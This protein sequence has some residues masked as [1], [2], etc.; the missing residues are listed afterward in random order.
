MK[1]KVKL[2]SAVALVATM[3]VS[4]IEAQDTVKIT[5]DLVSSYI[6]RGV[7][8]SRQ[9]NFQ[10]TF[11]Y[12][13]GP[14]EI[15]VWGSTDFT[16]AYKE[17]DLYVAYTISAFKVTVTDYNWNFTKSYFNY[18]NATTDHIFEGAI[19]YTGP[20]AFPLSVSLNTMLY[21]ADKKAT[22]PT[23]QAYSTYIELDYPVKTFTFFLGATPMDG[24]YGDGYGGYTGFS[25]CNLGVTSSKNLK[26]SESYSLPLKATLGFNPQKEDAYFVFGFTF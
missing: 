19:A 24:Y 2:L 25:V 10:P 3:C 8:S 1:N 17:A 23:K 22:D 14:F 18:K 5:S 4:S 21:G 15:G 7:Y 12:G 20:T 26:I 6:W 9:P 11:A 13:H 16:G